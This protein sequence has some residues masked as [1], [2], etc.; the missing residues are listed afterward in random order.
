[1]SRHIAILV[2][3][4]WNAWNFRQGLIRTLVKEGHQVTVIAPADGYEK[5]LNTLGAGFQN[6]SLD[7]TGTNPLKDRKYRRELR[8]ILKESKVD[9][10]LGFT[11]KPNIYGALACRSLGI[12]IICNVSGLGTTFLIKGWVRH[13]A[14]MLYNR[15]FRSADFVFFQNADD[16]A[17]FLEN[18]R[19]TKSMTGLLPGSGIDT[20][21]FKAPSPAFKPPVHFLMVSRLI[22]EKGVIEYAHAAMEVKRKHPEVKFTLIGTYDPGHSRSISPEAFL[23]VQKA[24]EHLGH[25][26]NIREHLETADVVVLPSYREGTPRTLL[27]AAAMSRPLIAT[28]VPGCREVVQ[29]GVNGFLCKAQ[30]GHSLA[31][32]ME[33]FIALTTEE[34][35]AMANAS[36]QWVQQ[37][38]DEQVVID[39]Y[40]RKIKQLAG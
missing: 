18:V 13:A 39:E 23:H 30:D 12:P 2:N 7:T 26:D 21:K 20:D 11:I 3:T 19:L 17:L 6:I 14:V 31:R 5:H 37:R 27:E 22:V 10:A 15:A 38:F 28:D 32:K 8:R 33:L 40:L 24:V 36:R 25:Q 16:R 9:I 1:M 4:A 35:Q 29:D 34:K